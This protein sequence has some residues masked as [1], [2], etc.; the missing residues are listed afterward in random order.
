MQLPTQTFTRC[1]AIALLSELQS[2]GALCLLA[3]C[4]PR[5]LTLCK[6][7]LEPNYPPY[8]SRVIHGAWG[9]V[10]YSEG[11]FDI[12]CNVLRR[13]M[14]PNSATYAAVADRDSDSSAKTTSGSSNAT[15]SS[16]AL[17]QSLSRKPVTVFVPL[18]E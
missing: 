15:K 14:T 3:T 1:Q 6:L 10:T 9:G 13:L 5:C 17:V 18:V 12:P 8:T 4:E 16:N 11:G 7:R 2:P